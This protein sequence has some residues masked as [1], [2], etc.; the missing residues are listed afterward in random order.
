[1]ILEEGKLLFNLYDLYRI[2]ASESQRVVRAIGGVS[3]TRWFVY[4]VRCNDGALYTG[5]A[6]NVRRRIEQHSKSDGKGSKYLRG[7]G[8]LQL[9]FVSEK[10]SR[11]QAL[12]VESQMKKLSKA[13][14]EALIKQ[15]E[16]SLPTNMD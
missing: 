10:E 2:A 6:T 11:G 1:M 7:K 9:V 8:P 14:K 5:I 3:M 12:R 15:Q 13:E 4:I 16:V